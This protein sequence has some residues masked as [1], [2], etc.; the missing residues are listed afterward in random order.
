VV[1][2]E[3]V[4]AELQ[5]WKGQGVVSEILL[6][7]DPRWQWRGNWRHETMRIWRYEHISKTSST[8]GAEATI[9]FVGTGAVLKGILLPDGGLLDIYLAGELSRTVDV[10]P[11]EP[12][13]KP[14]ESIWH[15]FDLEDKRHTLRLKVRGEPYREST[16]A[17]IS[18]SSLIVYRQQGA[19]G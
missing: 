6:Y 10:Y 9:S 4:P 3:A 14:E 17:K 18:I 15:H 12:N 16:G 5:T 19:A 1:L 8:L 13:A 7:D 11:D 2:Q